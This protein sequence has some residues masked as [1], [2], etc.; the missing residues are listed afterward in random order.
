MERQHRENFFKLIL[1]VSKEAFWKSIK[2]RMKFNPQ[3]LISK[4][5]SFAQHETD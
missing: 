1:L 5:F 3:H 2:L 4:K